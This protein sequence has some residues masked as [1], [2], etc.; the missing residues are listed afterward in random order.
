MGKKSRK[1]L[2]VLLAALVLLV[3]MTLALLYNNADLRH[4]ENFFF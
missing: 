4:P 2:G 1:L 3:A